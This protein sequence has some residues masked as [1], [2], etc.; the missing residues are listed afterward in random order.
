MHLYGAT[1]LPRQNRHSAYELL[2]A[3]LAMEFFYGQIRSRLEL[4]K[5][6]LALFM[7][8]TAD[9]NRLFKENEK[10][11]VDKMNG[12]KPLETSL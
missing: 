6:N 2:F 10:S 11:S 8:A 12:A 5:I 9:L 3:R 4:N 1:N 7:L